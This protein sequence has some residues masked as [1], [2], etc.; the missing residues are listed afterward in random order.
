MTQQSANSNAV[1]ENASFP[2]RTEPS[3]ANRCQHQF[4]NNTRCRLLTAH[5]DSP[6]CSRHSLQPDPHIIDA[7][8]SSAFGD[9]PTNFQSAVEINLFLGKLSTLLIQN[10]ISS[11]RASVLAYISSLEL[12]TLPAIDHEQDLEDIPRIVFGPPDP[13]PA[14]STVDNPS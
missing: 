4:S 1:N 8:L 11:R 2:V 5:P 9:E 10:R 13:V 14:T 7:G 3:P 6:F 12:R